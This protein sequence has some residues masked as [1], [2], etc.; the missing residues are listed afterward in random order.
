MAGEQAADRLTRSGGAAAAGVSSAFVLLTLVACS[1][2]RWD[3]TPREQHVVRSGETLYTIAWRYGRNHRDLARWNGLGDGS[4]ISPRPGNSTDGTAGRAAIRRTPRGN[5]T[6]GA[7]LAAGARRSAAEL[8]LADQWAESPCRSAVA[9]E[10]EPVVLIG[11]RAGQSVAQ[12][13]P[14]R[15]SIRAVDSALMASLLLSSTTTPT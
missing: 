6:G 8:G 5:A 2:A 9:R 1:T 7:T 15:W 14:A 11:G 13:P 12:R 3:H 10:A 4:L